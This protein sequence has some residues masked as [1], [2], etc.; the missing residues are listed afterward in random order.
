MENIDT[1]KITNVWKKEG[2][3]LKT[4]IV[5]FAVYIDKVYYV[6]RDDSVIIFMI[7]SNCD[8]TYALPKKYCSVKKDKSGNKYYKIDNIENA[9]LVSC[10]TSK[11]DLEKLILDNIITNPKC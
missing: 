9:S 8:T 3:E 6:I 4:P 2:K 7:P 10:P 11:N 5:L 1:K